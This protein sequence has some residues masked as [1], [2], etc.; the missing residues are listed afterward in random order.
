M[1][2]KRPATKKAEKAYWNPYLVGTGIGFL[3]IL[4]FF[5][6]G[7]GLGAIGA[8]SDMVAVAVRMVA[9]GHAY[10]NP[11]YSSYLSGIDHPLRDWVVIEIAGVCLGGFLS[12]VVS[13][14]FRF[15]V[16]K[17]PRVSS[18]VR[19][20]LA[21]SGGILMAYAAKVSRGCTSGL[22]LSG[23]SV[24]SPGAWIFMLSVFF[25]GYASAFFMK[26]LW[27]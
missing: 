18:P 27:T 4:S 10:S 25:G 11:V 22:A 20:I 21:F 9:P 8:F 7:R 12:G 5:V 2:E 17:G 19:L 13:G 15:E 16:I 23:G 24:M 6:T 26:K 1:P 14:R 3:I